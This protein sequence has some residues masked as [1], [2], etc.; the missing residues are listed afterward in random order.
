MF[1]DEA[2]YVKYLPCSSSSVCFDCLAQVQSGV[3]Q[4]R[5]TA[6]SSFKPALPFSHVP[7]TSLSYKTQPSSSVLFW[8]RR[9]AAI[10]IHSCCMFRAHQFQDSCGSSRRRS[11]NGKKQ[12]VT[13]FA[14]N[15]SCCN[16]SKRPPFGRTKLTNMNWI[17]RNV[18]AKI[19]YE[20]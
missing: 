17:D 10:P 11:S 20:G 15:R 13:P 7:E 1:H 9:S 12:S 14:I 16:S 6:S 18:F 4:R 5:V 19:T 8:P 3:A 2:F